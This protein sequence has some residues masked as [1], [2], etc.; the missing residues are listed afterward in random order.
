MCI[1]TYIYIY[2]YV[3]IYIYVYVYVYIYLSLSLHIYI[4]IYIVKYAHTCNALTRNIKTPPRDDAPRG[5]AGA[6]HLVLI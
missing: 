6:Q 4:Y 2:M 3:Y 1:Y 5:R